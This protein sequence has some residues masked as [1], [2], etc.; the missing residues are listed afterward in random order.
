MFDVL[1]A[2]YER[3][4]YFDNVPKGWRSRE[5]EPS[6]VA[7]RKH[8]AELKKAATQARREQAPLRRMAHLLLPT[9]EQPLS[10]A[11]RQI[12]TDN[13]R[14]QEAERVVLS[15]MHAPHPPHYQPPIAPDAQGSSQQP[16][17]C[18]LRVPPA[19]AEPPAPSQ[20]PAPVAASSSAFSESSLQN[21]GE[22]RGQHAPGSGRGLHADASCSQHATVGEKRKA[23]PERA[24]FT[25]L[26]VPRISDA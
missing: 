24:P 9:D 7:V 5:A 15:D 18:P 2:T 4:Q 8:Q 6:E 12:I 13:I 25:P 16:A 23:S 11:D 14:R 3:C 20:L 1:P 19:Q 17:L 26:S 10:D 21:E 22:N